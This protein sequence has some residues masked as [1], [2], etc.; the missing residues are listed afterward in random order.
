MSILMHKTWKVFMLLKLNLFVPVHIST[1]CIQYYD[2]AF[3]LRFSDMCFELVQ[4]N[5]TWSSSRGVSPEITL[6]G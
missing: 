5:L 4:K 6:C 1:W 3:H 2:P